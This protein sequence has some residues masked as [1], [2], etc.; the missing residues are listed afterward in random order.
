MIPAAG[1]PKRDILLFAASLEQS[2]EHPLAAAIV[3]AARNE[4][5]SLKSP[6]EFCLGHRQGR[7][8]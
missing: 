4:A 1:L 5:C 7:Y 6:A 8:G 2:S 3:A